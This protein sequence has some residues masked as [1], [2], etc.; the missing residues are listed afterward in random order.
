MFREYVGKEFGIIYISVLSC[1]IY[2][3]RAQ[4]IAA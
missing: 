3:C 1:S 2:L 4:L